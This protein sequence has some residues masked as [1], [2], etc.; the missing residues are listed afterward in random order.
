M[1]CLSGVQATWRMDFEDGLRTGTKLEVRNG[2]QSICTIPEVNTDS[3]IGAGHDPGGRVGAQEH[4]CCSR[5]MFNLPNSVHQW[6][7]ITTVVVLELT[8]LGDRMVCFQAPL[9]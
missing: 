2:L 5:P 3:P 6:Y 4:K 7:E 1:L 8:G 9:G